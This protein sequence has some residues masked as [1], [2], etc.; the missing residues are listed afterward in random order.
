ML[1]LAVAQNAAPSDS[2]S[3]PAKPLAFEVISIRPS[4]P[5]TSNRVSPATTLDGYRVTGQSMLHT[6]LLAYFPQGW[7]YW[8]KDNLSGAPGW[9]SDQY[10]I[11]AKVSDADLSEWQK[12]GSSLDKKPMFRAMLQAMLADRCHLI[13]HMI[14]GPPQSGWALELGKHAQH[15]TESRS[16]AELPVGGRLPGGGVLVPYQ[17]GEKPRL[18]MVAG[19]MAD[20]AATLSSFAGQPVQDHTGLTGHFDF[21]IDW[22]PYPDSKIPVAYRDPND[23]D[24]LSRWSLDALGLRYLPIKV[25]INTLVIDHIEKPSEN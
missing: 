24:P 2:A 15:L 14:P 21:A 9:L 12:Q 18:T 13:A 7:S 16:G 19:T 5:G 6:I 8:T 23:P 1:P 17:S 22:I 20:L 3:R 25:P 10:D 4:K 11:D